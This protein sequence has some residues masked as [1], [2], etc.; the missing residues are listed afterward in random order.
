VITGGS[1]TVLEE[2]S[3]ETA[4][5]TPR[6]DLTEEGALVDETIRDTAA[7]AMTEADREELQEQ[8]SRDTAATGVTEAGP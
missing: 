7:P 5:D 4:P 8:D 2:H 6:S 3:G 1:A